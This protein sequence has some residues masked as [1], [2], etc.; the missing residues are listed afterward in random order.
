MEKAKGAVTES[1]FSI[2][3]Q[4]HFYEKNCS[5]LKREVYIYII[6]YLLLPKNNIK[7][8]IDGILQNF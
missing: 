3:R 2:Y 8:D 7:D 5:A 4:I 1:N 6:Y